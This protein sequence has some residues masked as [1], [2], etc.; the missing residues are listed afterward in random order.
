VKRYLLVTV[1]MS[2]DYLAFFPDVPGCQGKGETAR[3]AKAVAVADLK[4]TLKDLT[5]DNLPLPEPTARV[6]YV[7]VN[8]GSDG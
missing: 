3:K 6:G 1:K 8:E 4:R 7:E 2:H 5:D